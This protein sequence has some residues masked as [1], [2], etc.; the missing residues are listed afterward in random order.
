MA[1]SEAY[2][3]SKLQVD[4]VLWCS[5]MSGVVSASND[6]C[7]AAR[8]LVA[9]SH[10]GICSHAELPIVLLKIVAKVKYAC[11]SC[12]WLLLLSLAFVVTSVGLP[13]DVHGACKKPCGKNTPIFVDRFN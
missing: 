6:C 10:A 9:I 1:C 12:S 5:D 3:M 8:H 7:Q 11:S 2:C 13:S 4:V